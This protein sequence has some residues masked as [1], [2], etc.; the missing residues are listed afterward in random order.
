MT[1][2]AR[3][4]RVTDP[5]DDEARARLVGAD[6]RQ[7]SSFSCGSEHSGNGDGE[8]D[9]LSLSDLVHGFLEEDGN[10]GDDSVV[11]EF[12][13]DRVDSADDFD[14]S[15]EDSLR[16]RSV[17]FALS[18]NVDP[19]RNKLLA[20][21]SEAADMFAFMRERNVSV[22]RRGVVAFLKEKGHDAAVCE[23]TWDSSAASGGR[24]PAGSHEFIDVV[25]SGSSTWRYFVDL[26][27]R[28]QFE[29][30]RPTRQFS[31]ILRLVPGV[32]VGR[33][34]ELKR[35][36]S[37]VCDAARRC[38]RSSGLPVPPW[39]KNRFMQNKWFAS[40]RRTANPVQEN[41]VPVAVTAVNG[42]SCRLVGFD[43]VVLEARR[44]GGVVRTRC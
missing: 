40:Y 34:E 9:A 6:H 44:G 8:G 18:N 16:W 23:T 3:K 27:F 41:P 4:K 22:F 43:N 28:A 7:L 25:Q 17:I 26:D 11:N 38:F 36:V 21:V 29:I 31:E 15:V 42:V 10:F 39:R 12:D 1:G 19:Y 20:H 24:V 5:F 35:T 14:D 2:L 30:A 32:F 13:S 33:S 37:I